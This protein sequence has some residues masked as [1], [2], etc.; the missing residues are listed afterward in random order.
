MPIERSY[1]P[2]LAC[3]PPP[4][5]LRAF[6]ISHHMN[7]EAMLV[8]GCH[9]ELHDAGL[10]VASLV[11]MKSTEASEGSDAAHDARMHVWC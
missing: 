9:D 11:S 8:Y 2:A 6:Y 3:A 7:C 10:A 1:C 5:A 4:A